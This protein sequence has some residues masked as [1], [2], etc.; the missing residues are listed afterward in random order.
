MY[1]VIP[2]DVE[3]AVVGARDDYREAIAAIRAEKRTLRNVDEAFLGSGDWR[4][5][6]RFGARK[7]GTGAELRDSRSIGGKRR[8]FNGMGLELEARRISERFMFWS[9]LSV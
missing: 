9:S 5:R 8:Y 7:R 2:G 6:N 1:L 4:G 3:V